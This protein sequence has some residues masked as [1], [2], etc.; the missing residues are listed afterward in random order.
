MA[1]IK[2]YM[3]RWYPELLLVEQDGLR[4][5]L[6]KRATRKSRLVLWVSLG[7]LVGVVVSMILRWAVVDP[8]LPVSGSL[9]QAIMMPLIAYPLIW[10]WGRSGIRQ[11]LRNELHSIGR[12]VCIH[13]GYDTRKLTENRCPE[14]G[15]EFEPIETK[16]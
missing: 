13:C 10:V 9:A 1:K 5:E 7:I 15:H 12:S 6:L 11:A 14:C 4:H 16:P 2:P 8:Y 3:L